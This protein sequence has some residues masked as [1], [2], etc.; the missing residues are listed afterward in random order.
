MRQWKMVESMAEKSHT[1]ISTELL[2][3]LR[4]KA[5]HT[6]RSE[7]DLI[8]EAVRRYL[9]RA[10]SL[11]ELLDRA[12]RW[13]REQSVDTLSEEEAMKLAVEEQHAWRRER[14]ESGAVQ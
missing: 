12:D 7:S 9:D 1:E 2:E 13:Q 4:R 5:R 8:D 6:G 10:G 3:E 11:A 14:R